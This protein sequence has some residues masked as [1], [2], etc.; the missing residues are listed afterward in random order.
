MPATPAFDNH[1]LPLVTTPCLGK[2]HPAFYQLHPASDNYSPAIANCTPCRDY[3]MPLL[4]AARPFELLPACRL[5]HAFATY[6][7]PSSSAPLICQLHAAFARYTMP[8][9]STLCLGKLVA[10]LCQRC[11]TSAN[12]SYMRLRQFWRPTECAP[13]AEHANEMP[14]EFFLI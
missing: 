11:P 2:L 8:L 6:T 9:P 5:H 14:S 4:I 3:T 10:C 13:I 12:F 7:P 1:C